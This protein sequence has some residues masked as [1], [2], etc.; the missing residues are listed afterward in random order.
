MKSL[1][2]Y[3]KLR[4]E[5][6][7]LYTDHMNSTG[8]KTRGWY[9]R[10]EYLKMEKKKHKKIYKHMKKIKK[11]KNHIKFLKTK[12]KLHKHNKEIMDDEITDLLEEISMKAAQSSVDE[13]IYN[14]LLSFFKDQQHRVR[15]D[16]E[17]DILQYGYYYKD[18]DMTQYFIDKHQEQ[19]ET[20]KMIVSNIKK[21]LY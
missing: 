21:D 9:K 8:I 18:R 13:L 17:N 6:K 16:M 10:K 3:K 1:K 19:I 14:A 15:A 11:A 5:S 4:H 7:R 2:Y 12:L 20:W